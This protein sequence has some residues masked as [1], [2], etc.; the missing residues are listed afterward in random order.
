MSDHILRNMVHHLNDEDFSALVILVQEE[1]DRRPALSAGYFNPTVVECAV[2][3]HS[4][5]AAIKA[6]RSRTGSVASLKSTKEMFD[7]TTLTYLNTQYPSR[8]AY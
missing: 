4:P 6:Y 1:K 8:G 5:L 2:Y 7:A 3:R